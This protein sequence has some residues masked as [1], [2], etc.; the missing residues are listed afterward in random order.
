[1]TRKAIIV[2]LTLGAVGT[3]TFSWAST[4]K[5]LSYQSQI[6]RS[7]ELTIVV[8]G[9]HI[10]VFWIQPLGTGFSVEAEEIYRRLSKT[11]RLRSSVPLLDM[12][13]NWGFGI[14]RRSGLGLWGHTYRSA[15]VTA[16]LWAPFILLATYPTIV[17]YRG[18][19]RRWRRRRRGL[20]LKCGYDLTGNESGVCPECGSEIESP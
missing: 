7:T 9:A 4:W 18:P 13:T 8:S 19:M 6:N 15:E 2:V 12:R 3:L 1:M 10:Q 11:G 14:N 20:C 17:F 5:P 16:P